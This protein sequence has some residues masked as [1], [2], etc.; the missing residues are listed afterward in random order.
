MKKVLKALALVG[1]SVVLAFSSVAA[2][3]VPVH[4]SEDLIEIEETNEE[5]NEELLT[6]DIVEDISENSAD[7]TEEEELLLAEEPSEEVDPAIGSAILSETEAKEADTKAASDNKCGEKATW[8][9][10]SKTGALVISGSGAMYDYTEDAPAPWHD[11]ASSIK[12]ITISKGITRIGNYAFRD[13]GCVESTGDAV[14]KSI[15]IPDTVKEIGDYAFRGCHFAPKTDSFTIPDSVTKLGKGSFYNFWMNCSYT[16]HD[17]VI[18]SKLIIGN[19]IKVIPE[20]CFKYANAAE[21]VLPNKLERIEKRAF[22]P[23]Y[24]ATTI[25]FPETLKYIGDYACYYDLRIYEFNDTYFGKI[26]FKGDMPQFGEKAFGKHCSYVEYPVGNKTYNER[27]I[28]EAQKVFYASTWKPSDYVPTHKAGDNITWSIKVQKGKQSNKNTLVLTGEG[29][30]YDYSSNDLPEWYPDRVAIDYLEID[31]RITSIGDYA[32]FSFAGVNNT[33]GNPIKLPSKLTKIGDYAFYN[34]AVDGIKLP[35][36]VEYI[37]DHAFYSLS[38]FTSPESS[39]PKGVKYIGDYAFYCCGIK[40][41]E[42][43]LDH[44]EYIGDC[45]FSGFDCSITTTVLPKTLKH[46]GAEAFSYR[47][48][49]SGKLVIPDSVTHIGEKAFYKCPNLTGEIEI[50]NVTSIERDIFY[51]TGITAITFGENLSKI[52]PKVNKDFCPSIKRATFNCRYFDDIRILLNALG[53]NGHEVDIYYPGGSGWNVPIPTYTSSLNYIAFGICDVTFVYPDKSQKIQKVAVGKKA[54]APT[55]VKLPEDVT[56]A[57]WYTEDSIDDDYKWDFDS[58]VKK[59][60]K[61]YAKTSHDECYVRYGVPKSVEKLNEY[62]YSSYHVQYGRKLSYINS[63]LKGAWLVGWYKDKEF[64]K[65][66][67]F[68]KPITSNQTFYS[69][70]ELADVV[71]FSKDTDKLVYDKEISLDYTGHQ[72]FGVPVIKLKY[73]DG[74]RTLVRGID[75]YLTYVDEKKD[76]EFKEPGT[77]AIR[78]LGMNNCTGSFEI[79][80]IIRQID[81]SSA[82][83]VMYDRVVTYQYDKKVHKHVPEIKQY[84]VVSRPLK[85]GV[86]YNLEYVDEDKP[87]SFKEPGTYIIKVKGI[88]KYTGVGE[89]QVKITDNKPIADAKVTGLKNVTYN[90]RYQTQDKLVVTYN[91]KTL[92]QN[93][94]YRLSYY[95]SFDAGTAKVYI[96]GIEDAGYYGNKVVTFTIKPAPLTRTKIS[97]VNKNTTVAYTGSAVQ[98]KDL[99]ISDKLSGQKVIIEGTGKEAFNSMAN[100]ERSDYDYTFEYKNNVNTG[101]AK[102]IIRGV[103]NYTGTI[104]KTFKISKASISEKAVTEGRIVVELPEAATYTKNKTTIKPVVYFQSSKDAQKKLLKVNKDYKLTYTNNTAVNNGTGKKVPTVQITGMS[105]FK[106]S[107]KRTFKIVP[108]AITNCTATAKNVKYKKAAGNY[109]TTIVVKDSN[110][111]KLVA[112][113]DYDAKHIVYTNVAT[114]AVLTSKDKVPAGTQIK[115]TIKGLGNYA[116]DGSI[117]CT[118]KVTK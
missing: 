79:K 29:P 70:W 35:Q 110:G 88:G 2:T 8:S 97:G 9:F 112:G 13:S 1:M 104:V 82:Y 5:T 116:S 11:N 83:P 32:F 81:I 57:G 99:V 109:K 115:A 90:G 74:Y 59:D 40:T 49:M 113:K 108:S 61:L 75:Y 52:D 62:T 44:V 15:K 37:G 100:Y 41:G 7:D 71:D 23:Y 21:L 91:G 96:T 68:D 64:T 28:A 4:A 46:I 42:I 114:G 19:G 111:Q 72:R 6:E 98:L 78:V 54:T 94:H 86:D 84:G 117:S 55:D 60:F 95:N 80:E 101:T 27:S 105:N 73:K 66:V 65:P 31:P 17:S 33:S 48:E 106:G 53:Y 67:D 50:K 102:V 20:E 12:T 92:K 18:G 47:K 87:G 43:D 34:D 76:G 45:A 25:E 16:S 118:Y 22:S 38:C 30:M 10:N 93:V 24:G 39:F 36:T 77:Y 63:G 58:P 14:L 69:K 85:E 107:I 103:N 26:I 56:F 51:G 3:A 89:I